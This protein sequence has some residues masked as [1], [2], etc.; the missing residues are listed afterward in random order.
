MSELAPNVPLPLPSTPLL[1]LVFYPD[2]FLNQRARE[3][4]PEEFGAGEAAGQPLTELA[5]SMVATMYDARG[6]GLAGPQIGVGLRIFTVDLSDGHQHPMVFINPELTLLEGP[7]E[8]S[9][10]GCLSIPEVRANVRRPGRIHVKAQDLKGQTFEFDA[11]GLLARVCQH[12][13]DHLNGVLFLDHIGPAARFLRRRKLKALEDDYA[14]RQR[15][16]NAR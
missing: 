7:E 15:R 9:E 16:K 8:E 6:I 2:P 14:F 3:V 13:H 5:T 4:T 11:D 10:E 12:E 1:D